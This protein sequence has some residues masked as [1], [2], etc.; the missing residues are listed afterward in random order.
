MLCVREFRIWTYSRWGNGLLESAVVAAAQLDAH[1]T[2]KF[3][4]ALD[5]AAMTDVDGCESALERAF[6]VNAEAP[7]AMAATCGARDVAFIHV[8]TDYV[9]DDES[10]TLY[11]ETAATNPV[12]IYGES[13]AVGDR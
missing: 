11:P 7:G 13:K 1:E 4:D 10:R 6:A 3:V 5:T 8:S 12:Q 9:F 2:D